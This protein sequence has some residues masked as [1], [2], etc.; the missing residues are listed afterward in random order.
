MNNLRTN[1]VQVA[2]IPE[3]WLPATK[4]MRMVGRSQGAYRSRAGAA[5]SVRIDAN[6]STRGI[7]IIVANSRILNK[8]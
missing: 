6:I 3:P 7:Q 5:A 8:P 4:P 1:D 2:S